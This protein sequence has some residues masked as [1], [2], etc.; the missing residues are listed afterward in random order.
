MDKDANPRLRD[1]S[2]DEWK[3]VLLRLLKY[4]KDKC[5]LL[6][7]HMEPEDMVCNAVELALS[8][9]RK[10]NTDKYP[11]VFRFLK[12][13]ID[14]VWHNLWRKQECTRSTSSEVEL[15]KATE[16]QSVERYE[17]QDGEFEEEQGSEIDRRLKL[18]EEAAE[19]DEELEDMYLALECGCSS[20]KE[21]ASML[22]WTLKKTY[23]VKAKLAK[24][25]EDQQTSKVVDHD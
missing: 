18:I 5:R 19:G 17:S 13:V 7:G 4:A 15:E 6:P 10:W 1:L 22:K 25:L 3:E 21:I 2:D 23:K 14:S 8:G 11:D 9:K 16:R 12:G 20:V 24:K